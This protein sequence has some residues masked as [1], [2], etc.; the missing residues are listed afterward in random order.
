MVGAYPDPRTDD[1]ADVAWGLTNGALLFREGEVQDAL[2]WLRRAT[3]AAA[4]AGCHRRAAELR[5]AARR[6]DA[7]SA[8]QRISSLPPNLAPTLVPPEGDLDALDAPDAL[9]VLE[10]LGSTDVVAVARPTDDDDLELESSDLLTPRAAAATTRASPPPP[11]SLPPP[12]SLVLDAV[13]ALPLARIAALADV[14]D[15]VRARLAAVASVETLAADEALAV[16]GL[17]VVLDGEVVVQPVSSDTAV[18]R[19]R[20]GDALLMQGSLASSVPLRV[21]AGMETATVAS[22]PATTLHRLLDPCPWVL[23]ELGE[24][25]DRTQALA[26]IALGPLGHRLDEEL[27]DRALAALEVRVLAAG[28]LVAERGEHVPGMIALC[29][30]SLALDP[31][32][33][34]P[35][36]GEFLFAAELLRGAAAPA[37]AVAGPGGALL[38]VGERHRT[39]ELLV[40]FPPLLEI[41]AGA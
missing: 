41:F 24:Q 2:S 7:Q 8:P 16:T 22:W 28:E 36:V 37:R 15:D 14:P 17:V 3:S 30:G 32:V 12:S 40:T 29:G 20:A 38:L 1:D 35:R 39:Q 10:S 31:G 21:V 18:S 4:Q 19:L 13:A 9:D 25:A 27:R 34:P 33:A 5:E 26:G 11:P 6:L 23:A